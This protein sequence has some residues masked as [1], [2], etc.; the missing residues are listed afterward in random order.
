MAVIGASGSGKSSLVRAGVIPALRRDERTRWRIDIITPTS[1]PLESLAARLTRDSESV[2]ATVTL[3]DDLRR[4]GR[5]LHLYARRLVS[6][7]NTRLLLVVDQF[8]ELFT[9]CKDPALRQA[10]VDNLLGAA[11]S[12]GPVT[13]VLTLR[14]DFYTHCQAEWQQYLGNEP[15]RK[16]CE[17]LPEGL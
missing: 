13:V 7:D 2:T 6:G 16:T 9:A 1:Q 17:N 12:D 8:E 14:A 10:F 5:A 15:Y 11:Q 4:D 3:I